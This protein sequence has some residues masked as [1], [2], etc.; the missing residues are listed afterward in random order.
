MNDHLPQVSG[1]VVKKVRYVASEP[2]VDVLP[3]FIYYRDLVY[4]IDNTSVVNRSE[5]TEWITIGQVDVLHIV[6][7][8]RRR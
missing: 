6:L 4:Q 5:W 1:V 2:T 3:V 7:K 8:K